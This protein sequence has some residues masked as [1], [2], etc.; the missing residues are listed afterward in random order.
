MSTTRKIAHNTIVQIVG[1]VVSTA[2]GLIAIAMMTRYLG[3]EQ[4]GWYIT[5]ISF[6]GFAGILID[7]GL[8]PVTAQM[9][10]EPKFDKTKLFQNLLGFRFVTALIFLLLAP[11]IAVL[12]PY[13]EQV[14]QAILIL[15][16]SFLGVAM[17]QVLIGYY[18]TKLQMHVQAIGESIGRIV[19][20]G[21]LWLLMAKGYAFLPIMS[22]VMLSGVAYTIVLWAVAATKTPVTFRFDW[23]IWKA[24]M[25][26]MWPIAIAIIFNVV[27][28]KGD[29]LILA[30]FDTQEVVGLYGAAYRVIDI[31][32]QL[33]MMIMGIMLPLLTFA[34]SRKL[35]EDFK[36]RYQ[37]AFD[38]MMLLAFPMMLGTIL[39]ADKIMVFVAGEEFIASGQLLQILAIAVFGLYLGAVFGHAAVAINKQKQTMWIYISNA[40]LTLIGYL[41]FVPRFGALG[42]AWMTV[43]S[44]LYAGILLFFT[45]RHYTKERLHMQTFA[46]VMFSGF[47]MAALLFQFS[48]AHLFTLI[49]LGIVSYGVMVLSFG[50]VSKQTIREITSFKK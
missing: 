48:S 6:L 11:A 36:K 12:M 14:K 8:V 17:N 33:A 41:I 21:G 24:I 10:S 27:Y 15:T 43:F 1:K 39:L 37:Q 44:E 30:Y 9:M 4:F 20:V 45:I 19:L 16:V 25:T 46:K 22:I 5:A 29:V 13:P 26:K 2:L 18:Q 38:I 47:V 3:I 28:L 42:A 34:W 50:V 35:K 49:L 32:S 31:L 23:H 40:F 7:F